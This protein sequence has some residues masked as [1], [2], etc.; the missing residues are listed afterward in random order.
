MAKLKD[1]KPHAKNANKGTERGTIQLEES[2]KRLG[3][4][5]G[6]TIDKNGVVIAGN[7]ALQAAIEVGLQDAIIVKTRG[8]EVVVTQR[9][10][11]DLEKDPRAIELAY[12]DNRVSEVNY[13]LD[14]DQLKADLEAGLDLSTYYRE[15]ELQQALAAEPDVEPERAHEGGDPETTVKLVMTAEQFAEFSTLS[16]RLMEK[17]SLPDSTHAVL[18]AMRRA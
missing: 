12:A 2:I 1:L 10:D 13:S 3:F 16:K 15:D 9:E 5:R 7:H 14:A 18:E 6:I 17:W 11:L 8:R 4:G